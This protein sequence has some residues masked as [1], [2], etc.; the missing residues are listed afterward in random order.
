VELDEAVLQ[1]VEGIVL[2]DADVHARLERRAALPDQDRAGGD[3]LA[4]E[5]LHAEALRFAVAPVARAAN[6]FFVR[7][8]IPYSSV[9]SLAAPAT[10]G[11]PK[12]GPSSV[13]SIST[14]SSR[15]SAPTPAS[16]FSTRST[17]FSATRY[18]LPPVRTIAYI[19]PLFNPGRP[20]RAR[21]C[22]Q[23]MEAA[24]S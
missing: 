18:C 13:P 24:G 20:R 14:S 23:R 9:V 17:W 8:I 19:S 1:R 11:A 22:P 12:V 7:H 21:V 10:T 3:L 6:S 16:S 5:F 2:A 15:T 4:A